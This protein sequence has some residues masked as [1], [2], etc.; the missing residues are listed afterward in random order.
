MPHK[1]TLFNGDKGYMTRAVFA[2]PVYDVSF[3]GL[4]EGKFV[5]FSNSRDVLGEFFADLYNGT[6]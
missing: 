4:S 1:L 5:H 2:E 3:N 6:S